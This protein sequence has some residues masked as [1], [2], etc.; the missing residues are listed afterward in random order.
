MAVLDS[1]GNPVTFRTF[2]EFV[3]VSEP[4]TN[5][6]VYYE[7]IPDMPALGENAVHSAKVSQ[8]VLAY[9][10]CCHFCL[11]NLLYDEAKLWDARYHDAIDELRISDCK[12][13][14]IK[15]NWIV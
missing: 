9:G 8:R 10:A 3:K 4:Q 1:L 11:C 6:D 15:R 12:Q 13:K 5:Y 14:R 7:K 2:D